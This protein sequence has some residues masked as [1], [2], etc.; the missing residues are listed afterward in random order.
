MSLLKRII[1]KEVEPEPQTLFQMF[2]GEPSVS[3]GIHQGKH[4]KVAIF[5]DSR[6]P[7]VEG[8]LIVHDEHGNVMAICKKD[9][10]TILGELK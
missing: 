3:V 4:R 5:G 8:H 6:L 1:P 7:I 2:F 10:E 9:L